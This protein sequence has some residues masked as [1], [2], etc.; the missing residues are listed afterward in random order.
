[1]Q[2]LQKVLN[3]VLQ[4]HTQKLWPSDSGGDGKSVF[5]ALEL[6]NHILDLQDIRNVKSFIIQL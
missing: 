1:M 2:C 4:K 5:P 3:S 6:R